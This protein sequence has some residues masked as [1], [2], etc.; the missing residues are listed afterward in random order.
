MFNKSTYSTEVL[1]KSNMSDIS[2]NHLMRDPD[3]SYWNEGQIEIIVKAHVLLGAPMYHFSLT[4]FCSNEEVANGY[5]VQ[6]AQHVIRML[7]KMK[8]AD[9]LKNAKRTDGKPVFAPGAISDD[10]FKSLGGLMGHVPGMT[11]NFSNNTES[12]DAFEVPFSGAK[13]VDYIIDE[14]RSPRVYHAPT[15]QPSGFKQAITQVG[16][17]IG[18]VIELCFVLEFV[19]KKALTFLRTVAHFFKDTLGLDLSKLCDLFGFLFDIDS[20]KEFKRF[21]PIVWV[22][23]V[24]QEE[25]ES[26]GLKLHM[27]NFG[28]ARDT[29]SVAI[30]GWID[31]PSSKLIDLI[32][33]VVPQLAPFFGAPLQAKDNV[34]SILGPSMT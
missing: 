24:L 8:S 25:S 2:I 17:V 9:A 1:Y 22:P 5:N 7:S 6:P 13:S 16:E 14:N 27:T 33:H 15:P 18:G 30:G 26:I 34:A 10:A 29:M 32:S 31:R 23:E 4:D 21:N 11:Q 19:V 28:P 12:G 3:T 20:V